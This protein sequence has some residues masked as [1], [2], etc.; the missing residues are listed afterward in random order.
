MESQETTWPQGPNSL[1]LKTTGSVRRLLAIPG[2]ENLT[3]ELPLDNDTDIEF[4]RTVKKVDER[5]LEWLLY[6][7]SGRATPNG[8]TVF[9]QLKAELQFID[10]RIAQLVS[11]G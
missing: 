2:F 3:V 9:D 11:K 7:N 8:T 10:G 5:L 1:R 4:W 6:L